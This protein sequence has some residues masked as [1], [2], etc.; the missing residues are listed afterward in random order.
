MGFDPPRLCVQVKSG[1]SPVGVKLFREL[2]GVVQ[3]FNADQ[4]L[5]VSWG[6]FNATV[7]RE[8]APSFFTIRLWDSGDLLNAI[9]ENY[10]KFPDELQAALPLKS[11]WMLAGQE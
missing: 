2:R 6:G 10:D 3:Q 5:L 9:L 11:F 1:R 8:A 4:G 7:L